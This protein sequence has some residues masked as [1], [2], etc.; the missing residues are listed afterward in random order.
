MRALSLVEAEPPGVALQANTNCGYSQSIFKGGELFMDTS[1]LSTR[2]RFLCLTGGLAAGL[3]L[4]AIPS[5]LRA[6]Q[7]QEAGGNPAEDLMSEHGVLRRV[8]LIYDE[9]ANR[10]QRNKEI[11]FEAIQESADITR[12]FIHDYHEKLEEEE[13]FPRLQTSGSLSDLIPVLH[14]QHTAGRRLT[15]SIL[16][17][18]RPEA[19]VKPAEQKSGNSEQKMPEAMQQIYGGT[20]LI[21]HL[22]G[23]ETREMKMTQEGIPHRK[24]SLLVAM[25]Q[26]SHMYRPHTAR[27]DT[28][29]FTAFL[30]TVS[31]GEFKNLAEKFDDRQRQLLGEN[32]YG[33]IVESIAAVEKRLGIYDLSQFT[34]QA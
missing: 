21:T 32:G 17:F 6:A 34:S 24:Q 22:L 11:P 28:V 12:R 7:Q 18:S 16:R 20:P 26:F 33:N 3:V 15:E 27:E 14:A 2:R 5:T 13:I 29:V 19:A 30:S 23:K 10:I 8:L 4:P 25:E 1:K 31:R 9:A